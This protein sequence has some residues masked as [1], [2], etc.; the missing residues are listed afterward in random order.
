MYFKSS[1][2]EVDAAG[3]F[4]YAFCAPVKGDAA[5]AVLAAPVRFELFDAGGAALP[6]APTAVATVTQLSNSSVSWSAQS[7]AAGGLT[8]G[9]AGSLDFTSYA[10]FAVTISNAG[11]AAAALGD[12]RLT[13]SVAPQ[14]CGYIVGMDNGGA[15][16][17]EAADREWRWT[18]STGAN[19]LWIG[20]TE[21]GA[22]LNLKGDG[23]KWD[24]PMFGED[25]PVIPFV[26]P[27][28]GGADAQPVDNLFGVSFTASTCTAV[29]FSGPRT[30]AP[31]ASVVFRFDLALTPSKL[32]NYTRHFATRA[33]QV[34]YG[35][36][37]YTPQQM[38]DAGVTAVTLH[39]GTPGIINGSLVNPWINYP[40]LN[41]T[42]PLLTNYSQQANAL[43]L[44]VRFYY[45]VRE[46]SSRAWEIFAFKALQGELL[47]EQDPYVIVQPGYAH[48]WNTH[49]G[50]AF[51]H[52]HGGASYAA[53]WQQTETNGEWDPSMCSIGVSRLFNYYVE[54]LFWGMKRPPFMSGNYYDGTN[55]SNHHSARA[56]AY[57]P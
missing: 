13:L 32:S 1:F 55:V 10:E 14:I 56:Y 30:L 5:N 39:Q 31:G 52:Q 40:F 51:L 42:V 49:G 12:V 26:P 19:K 4:S 38:A 9:V 24:S 36:D 33:F 7:A 8:I 29:A 46:L 3:W 2:D 28:W 11:A 21:G 17:Q 41:D 15:P 27:T 48:A 25:F 53:C 44:L 20:R 22:L 18:N 23:I 57:A 34:G 35:T 16:A 45:T 47:V 6:A 37:Y 54:G 43:G 50:S